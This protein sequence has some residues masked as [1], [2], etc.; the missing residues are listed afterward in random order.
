MLITESNEWSTVSYFSYMG[1]ARQTGVSSGVCGYCR[2]E[3][4]NHTMNGARFVD[5][6][7]YFPKRN[8]KY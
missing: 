3:T 6:C 2:G 5:F 7:K 1:S 8:R 4:Q